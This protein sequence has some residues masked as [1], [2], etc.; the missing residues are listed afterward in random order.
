VNVATLPR[1][2]MHWWTG[3]LHQRRWKI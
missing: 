1:T 3:T 2:S